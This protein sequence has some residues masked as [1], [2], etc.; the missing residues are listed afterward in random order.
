MN[1]STLARL[2][3]EGVSICEK[4]EIIN[5]SSLYCSPSN[6]SLIIQAIIAFSFISLIIAS[7][8]GNIVVMWIIYRHKVMHHAFNIFL[9]N[10]ALA[11]LLIALFNVGTS[12]TYNVY[13]DWWYGDLCPVTLFFGVA[14]TCVS[15]FSMMALSWDRCQAVVNPLYR[16]PLSIKKA[17]IR[18]GIIWFISSLIALPNILFYKITTGIFYNSETHSINTPS[19]CFMS[20]P[21][22]EEYIDIPFGLW[23]D[24]SL[25]ILQYALPLIILTL[26]FTRIAYVLRESSKA[27]LL[28]ST[29]RSIDPGK[30]KRKV[31]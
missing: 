30:A 15:V 1:D 2:L 8:T 13:Y 21:S 5:G 22:Y 31:S 26:T 7:I 20:F 11:D 3:D 14:P 29:N 18:I 10:M 6:S 9:F 28:R 25:F 16:R 17:L 23:Y 4:G 12:W 24:R 27:Q 19:T